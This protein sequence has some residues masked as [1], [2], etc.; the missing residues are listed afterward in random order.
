MKGTKVPWIYGWF[1][2]QGGWE[3]IPETY[4]TSNMEAEVYNILE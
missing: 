2:G 4:L 1:E 3:Q